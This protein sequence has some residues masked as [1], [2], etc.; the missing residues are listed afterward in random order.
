MGNAGVSSY[1]QLPAV[2]S[3]CAS[4]SMVELRIGS[5]LLTLSEDDARKLRTDLTRYFFDRDTD[6][7]RIADLIHGRAR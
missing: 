5:A 7:E 1:N 2:S 6:P 4:C 3:H